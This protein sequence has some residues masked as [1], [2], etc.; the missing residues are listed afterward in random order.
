MAV[1]VTGTLREED[2]TEA[3]DGDPDERDAHWNSPRTGVGLLFGAEVYTIG[4]E[5]PESDEQL[6]GTE[7]VLAST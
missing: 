2:N 3:K 1:I 5:N 7:T 6:V 4:N